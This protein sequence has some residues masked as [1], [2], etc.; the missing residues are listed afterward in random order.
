MVGNL[1]NKKWLNLC[2]CMTFPSGKRVANV[3][4]VQGRKDR[5]GQRINFHHRRDMCC[6]LP[7]VKEGQGRRHQ[8]GKDPGVG[9][10]GEDTIPQLSGFTGLKKEGNEQYGGGA[11][12][13][14]WGPGGNKKNRP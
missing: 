9:D 7:W 6:V 1:A 5:E 12:G 11:C 2:S 3:L 4:R 14:Q 13:P 8:V 10:G